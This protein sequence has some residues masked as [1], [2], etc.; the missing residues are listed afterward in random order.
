MK[1]TKQRKNRHTHAITEALLS[2]GDLITDFFLER[3]AERRVGHDGIE[4]NVNVEPE[5]LSV[6]DVAEKLNV[7]KNTVRK[8]DQEGVLRSCTI[9]GMRSRR[10]KIDD[11]RRYVN[12]LTVGEQ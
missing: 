11:V 7:S 9:P 1:L 2:L 12:S 4:I 8:L 10:W 5:L 6:E 3:A